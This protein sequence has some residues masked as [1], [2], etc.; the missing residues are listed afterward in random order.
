[1][2]EHHIQKLGQLNNQSLENSMMKGIHNYFLGLGNCFGN[3]L[4]AVDNLRMAVG[5]C[6]LVPGNWISLAHSLG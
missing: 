2:E 3:C 6:C 4:M 5:N 1:M